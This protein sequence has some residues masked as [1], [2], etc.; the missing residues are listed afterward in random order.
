M[1][2]L[3]QRYSY[4]FNGNAQAIDHELVNAPLLKHF[5]KLVY[6]R[7][8]ADYPATY[9]NDSTRPERLSDHDPAVAYF[10]FTASDDRRRTDKRD[11]PPRVVKP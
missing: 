2:A 9:R 5:S 6:A 1:V 10:T 4:S 3:P 7:T 8:N 11:V